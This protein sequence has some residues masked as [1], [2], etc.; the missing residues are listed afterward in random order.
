MK[1]SRID[2]WLPRGTLQSLAEVVEAGK[3]AHQ[4]ADGLP[5]A[6]DAVIFA[7]GKKIHA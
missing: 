3:A 6:G 4:L 1:I 2:L 5:S 7:C